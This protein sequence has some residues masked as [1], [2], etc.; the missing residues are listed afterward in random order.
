M[1]SASLS[2]LSGVLPLHL[3]LFLS[4][5]C[6]GESQLLRCD[7]IQAAVWEGPFIEE[8]RHPVNSQKE[9]ESRGQ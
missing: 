7:D 5:Q 6:L 9:T 1:V 2:P 8:Q 3:P 4:Y